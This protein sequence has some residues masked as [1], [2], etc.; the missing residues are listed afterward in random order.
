MSSRRPQ[1]H[2][3]RMC[4]RRFK[5]GLDEPGQPLRNFGE[6]AYCPLS[7]GLLPARHRRIVT[8][9]GGELPPVAGSLRLYR[10]G[11][12]SSCRDTNGHDAPPMP[13]PEQAG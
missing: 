12:R 13:I 6:I 9:A 5:H 2:H 11:R 7:I 4:A 10:I 3:E 8:A 1:R